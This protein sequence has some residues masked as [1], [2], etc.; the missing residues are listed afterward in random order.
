M[1]EKLD[2]LQFMVMRSPTLPDPSKSRRD[3]IHDDLIV[4]E[5][6]Y[7]ADLFSDASNS[8]I[9]KLIYDKVFCDEDATMSRRRPG[10][11]NATFGSIL[12]GVLEL[13]E[14]Y[15][16]PC[17]NKAP[18]DSIRLETL[19]DRTFFSIDGTRFYL[20]PEQLKDLN[21]P[22][23]DVLLDVLVLL[24]A[25]DSV[26]VPEDF[27]KVA[28]HKALCKLLNVKQLRDL[29]F[30]GG[31]NSDEFAQAKRKLFDA[32]YLL[33]ILRRRISVNLEQI[34]DGLR[35]LHILEA[36]AIDEFLDQLQQQGKPTAGDKALLEALAVVYPALK[37]WHFKTSP[38]GLP[39]ISKAQDLA[40][41]LSASPL[42]HPIFA[43][44]LYFRQP[45]NSIKP[46][47][48]GD[49]KVVKQ[50]LVGYK[51]GE[52]AH[53]DNVLLGETKTRTHRHLERT[54]ET[55]SYSSEQQEE[56]QR[57][58]QTTDR[59]ELKRESENVVKNDLNITAGLSVSASYDGGTYKIQAGVTGGFAYTRSQTET[60]KSAENFARDVVDK[61]VKRVQSRISQQRTTTK[62]FETEETN[63]HTFTNT[64]PSKQ[65]ISGIY[66]W[67]DKEYK[68]QLFNYGKRLMYEFVLPEPAAFLVESRL[69]SYEAGIELP[70]PPQKPVMVDLPQW[71]KYLKP[72]SVTEQQFNIW[73]QQYDL[74]GL[75]QSDFPALTRQVEFID[76]ATGKNFFSERG[77]TTATWQARTYTCRLGAKGYRL[78]NFYATGYLA[79]GGRNATGAQEA[80]TI[81]IRVAG[82]R[83]RRVTNENNIYW[84]APG[85]EL[86]DPMP[87]NGIAFA[88]DD[89]T[90]F[91]GFWDISWF[92]L[93]FNAELRLSDEALE[94]W[95]L[96]VC[97]AITKIEQAKVD[98]QNRAL[99]QA[100]QG[101]LSTYHNRLAELRAKAINDL[102]QGQT[103]V[104]NRQIILRELK[105]Q[106]L[107]VLT[108]EFDSET[109]DD[110][111]T[112]M[113]A[114]GDRDV[115]TQFRRF[116]VKEL[117]DA[118]NPTRVEVNFSEAHKLVNFPVPNLSMAKGKGR[119]IQ[120][121]EQAFE[122]Q[123][124]SYLMYPYFWA[125]PPKWI[126]LMNRSDE[127]D[128]FLS[129]FLQAGSAR[130]L[131][132]VTPGYDH[133]VLHYLATG[134]PWE[135]G[136]SPVIGD[137]LFIPLYEEVKK[138]LDDLANATPEGEPWPFTLPTSLVY[139]E[140]SSTP[141]PMIT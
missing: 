124:L 15:D 12:L 53:I 36:M 46:I 69:R 4:E 57:D 11:L 138:Q 1:A 45:F 103:E 137:K 58:T 59:F 66:R 51:P 29:V 79:F 140:N 61:A 37:T 63:V 139:L 41:Y 78:I 60:S 8:E 131:L 73:R 89:V 42:V 128:S 26:D 91:L 100:Y 102:L 47:G 23:I 86:P 74:S 115:V 50:W 2:I 35:A 28:T 134:E 121:L 106:C 70:R 136:P 98:E 82:Q 90:L 118:D 71:V 13:L 135:G 127:S 133:A 5:G 113:E 95:Q 20:L 16:A 21:V 18:P 30:V 88:S 83:V 122:W 9:G 116:D 52:I 120:F 14:Y 99:E 39:L 125:T 81:D 3:Y 110:V 43:R 132:A 112:D 33:Y 93:S 64:S 85:P 49:L 72:A 123:Q 126:D 114:M 76:P 97:R 80:N 92:D 105:R 34:I 68:A 54:E 104:F 65:H 17:P 22:L 117:P 96:E 31:R 6:I 19:P 40:D 25:A 7:D 55:F 56:T 111:L 44:L 75:T 101:Q 94:S 84:S 119:Y 67:V 108:K 130:V 24:R 48:I 32:L 27:D 109:D 141:L 77:M 38:Q 107:A 129:A 10:D 62:L 87:V